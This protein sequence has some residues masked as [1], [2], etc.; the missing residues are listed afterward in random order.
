MQVVN[1]VM[2]L[3]GACGANQNVVD[4]KGTFEEES[5]PAPSRLLSPSEKVLN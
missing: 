4:A 5:S 3:S 2:K 1:S